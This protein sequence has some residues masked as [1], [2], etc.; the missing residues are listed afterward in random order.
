MNDKILSIK[1]GAG[2]F[3]NALLRRILEVPIG[4]ISI[5]S[6]DDKK[7]DD[8]RERH[9]DPERKFYLSD[10]WYA[11]SERLA[12]RGVDYVFHTA[13]LKQLPSCDFLH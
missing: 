8:M 1:D 11:G 12:M 13:A 6:R 2:S 10:V 5:L 4:G 3:G 9:R 7:Q